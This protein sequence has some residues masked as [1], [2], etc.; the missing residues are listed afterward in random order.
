VTSQATDAT[1]AGDVGHVASRAP[2]RVAILAAI[3]ALLGVVVFLTLLTSEKLAPPKRPG[4]PLVALDPK[5]VRRVDVAPR[6]GAPY[7]F[8]R[9]DGGWVIEGRGD[10]GEVPA[11]RLDGFLETLTAL[12][13]LVVIDE[14]DPKLADFGLDPPRAVVT[15]HGATDVALAI[16]DRNPP[17][18]ALYVQILPRTNI[19]LVGAV[20]LWEFDKLASL[21]K[22]QPVEP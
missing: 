14:P 17:L 2:R 7:S 13:R 6:Q 10:D 15:I 18:T 4:E 16:G 12:T 21:A 19:V 9:K 11:D 20:L 1:S 3:A 22:S 5:E 8:A